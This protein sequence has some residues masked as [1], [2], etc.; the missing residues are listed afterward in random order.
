[1]KKFNLHLVSDSTGETVCSVARATLVQFEGIEAKEFV[2]SLIR[3][4][5]Q[6]EKITK[7]I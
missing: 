5:G 1:M 7:I 2:W 3:T 4:P 6:I